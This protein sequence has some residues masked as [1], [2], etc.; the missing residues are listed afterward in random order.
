MKTKN[1]FTLIELMVVIAIIAI[2]VSLITSAIHTSKVKKQ[3]M[4]N[5]ARMEQ[6]IPK[7]NEGDLVSIDGMDAT[8]KVNSVNLNGKF[9]ILIR[10]AEGKI[11]NVEGVSGNLLRK[12]HTSLLD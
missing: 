7:F 3:Q 1:A 2:L 8:G 12:I 4:N 5:K 9:D 10:D 6:M 11:Q